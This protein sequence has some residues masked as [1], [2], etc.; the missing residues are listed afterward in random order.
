MLEKNAKFGRNFWCTSKCLDEWLKHLFLTFCPKLRPLQGYTKKS[1]L[2]GPDQDRNVSFVFFS[3]NQAKMHLIEDSKTP[4]KI[5]DLFAEESFSILVWALNVVEKV[6][7]SR[8]KTK[9]PPFNFEKVKLFMRV[10]NKG[11]EISLNCVKIAFF[12]F[13]KA[14]KSESFLHVRNIVKKINQVEKTEN[15]KTWSIFLVYLVPL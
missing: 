15:A 4:P 10:E 14:G 2:N 6:L 13:K 11:L 12:T 5:I 7:F 1:E 3:T 8:K 9:F